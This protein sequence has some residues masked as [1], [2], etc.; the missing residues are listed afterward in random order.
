MEYEYRGYTIR[1]VAY[2]DTT[3]GQVQ[4]H[5]TIEMRPHTGTHPDHFTAPGHYAT[6][7]E[8]ERGAQQVAL[9]YLDRK[10]AGLT[11]TH[12]PEL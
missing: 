6:R 10:L 2:E 9:E 11:A 1:S 5:C 4:W 7:E 8:A 3:G 12:H